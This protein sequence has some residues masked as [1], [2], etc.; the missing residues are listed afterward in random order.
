MLDAKEE[1][2]HWL[3]HMFLQ[4]FVTLPALIYLVMVPMWSRAQ[5]FAN[6]YAFA[7]LDVLYTSA[8]FASPPDDIA[9]S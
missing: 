9:Q 6:A 8:Y 7:A 2:V 5:K 4:C 3:T 1:G